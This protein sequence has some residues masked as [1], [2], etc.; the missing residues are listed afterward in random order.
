MTPS[1]ARATVSAMP[2]LRSSLTAAATAAALLL[3]PATAGARPPQ[4]ALD[5]V[6]AAGAPG[7]IALV[8]GHATTAGVA[9]VRTGRP[10][11]AGDPVRIGSV[12][13]SFTAVVALQLVGEGRLSLDDSLGERL[14]GVLP[15][16]DEIT[17][18]QLLDHRSGVPEGSVPS[19][20]EELFHG[21][22]LPDLDAAGDHRPRPRQAAA[23]AGREGL[24]VQPHRLRPRRPHDRAR[25]PARARARVERRILRRWARNK[26]ADGLPGAGPR[27][28]R[29]YSLDLRPEWPDRGHAARDDRLLT[30]FAWAAATASPPRARRGPLVPRVPRRPAAGT[31]LLRQALGGSRRRQDRGA[32]GLGVELR[33]T[34]FGT[35]VGHEGDIARFSVKALLKSERVGRRPSS[36]D[37]DMEFAAAGSTTRSTRPGTPRR[38]AF[39]S[40]SARGAA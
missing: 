20:L 8:D 27:A 31:R 21:D 35:L 37:F 12:T 28:P 14:P 29:G 38:A 25:P 34:R 39:R 16:G 19:A 15:Y 3:L 11:R 13:K 18:R 40:P 33:D 10:L 5:R 1:W 4:A 23:L 9:D 2:T 17:L 6:V 7:A 30:S 36:A 22:P 32:A 24:G 26:R